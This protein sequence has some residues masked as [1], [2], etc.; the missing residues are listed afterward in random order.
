MPHAPDPAYPDPAPNP[1]RCLV[2]GALAGLAILKLAMLAGQFTQTPPHPPLA[3][4]PLF[5][6]SLAL[7]ALCAALL[8]ARSH[9]FALPA[10]LVTLESLLSFGPHK[11]YPGPAPYFAQTSAVYPVIL[12]GSALIA[13][14]VAGSW[15]LVRSGGLRMPS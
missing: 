3:F 12:V 6:A 10:A 15:K 4:A 14:L 11:L 7:C 9:W 13:L 5:A 1:D 8:I 2:L